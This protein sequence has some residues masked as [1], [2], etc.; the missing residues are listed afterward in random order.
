MKKALALI[1]GILAL[2]ALY[3]F[4]YRPNLLSNGR[5]ARGQAFWQYAKASDAKIVTPEEEGEM[6]YM[7]IVPGGEICQF[8]LSGLAPSEVCEASFEA[9]AK[10]PNGRLT[11]RMDNHTHA[12]IAVTNS[13]WRTVRFRFP[14]FEYADKRSFRLVAGKNSPV[15]VRD[16]S[17]KRAKPF[18]KSELCAEEGNLVTNL[19]ANGDFSQGTSFW[20]G[21]DG[22]DFSC[23]DKR[24]VP[25]LMFLQSSNVVLTASQ[26]VKV[27][28]GVP[29]VVCA[30]ALMDDNRPVERIANV[31]YSYNDG[32]RRGGDLKFSSNARGAWQRGSA[33]ITPNA[34]CDLTLTLRCEHSR[35]K[36][37]GKVY[38]HGVQV[39]PADEVIKTPEPSGAQKEK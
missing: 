33:K 17:L 22:N 11:F 7:A 26:T 29:Y 28:K 10:N 15:D 9:R 14:I 20:A 39:Y 4:F 34:D 6:A 13:E 3:V 12:V 18:S 37:R 30:Y 23:F 38:F 8:F 27:K 24:G 36:K 35:G 21:V 19:V 32:G 2:Y 25:T 31:R 1:A 16:L 5:F